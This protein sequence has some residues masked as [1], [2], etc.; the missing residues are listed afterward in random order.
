M[1]KIG[2]NVNTPW[3]SY[4]PTVLH[5]LYTTYEHVNKTFVLIKNGT[6]FMLWTE[7]Y[8]LQKMVNL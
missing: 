1:G 8:N 2:R 7:I 4:I 3:S 6:S 5:I